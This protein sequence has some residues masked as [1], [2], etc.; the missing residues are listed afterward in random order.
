MNREQQLNDNFRVATLERY[1]ILDT[2]PEK[3]LDDITALAAQICGTP[4]AFISLI[5]KNRQWFKSKFG[6]EISQT[7]RNVAF[8]NHTIQHQ[9]L[10]IVPDA[11]K[12]ERFVNN[13]LVTGPPNICFYAGTPLISPDGAAIGALCVIDHEPRVLT[14][15]QEKGLRILGRQVI[16]HLELRCKAHELLESENKFR[17]LSNNIDDVLW[18][19]STD[20]KEVYYVSLGYEK[21]WGR[22]VMDLYA[23]SQDW[24]NTI[25]PED[26]QMVLD[27]LAKLRKNK[28]N[29]SVE[30]RIRRPNGEIR[31]IHGRGFQVLNSD[32]KLERLT[33]IASDI[34]ENK[35]ADIAKSRL[36]AIVEFSDDAIIG[37]DL[38]SIIT[39]WNRGAEKIFGYTADEMVGT[40]IM[41]LIPTDRIDEEN[42][43]LSKI[44]NGESVEH[45]ETQR[46]TKDGRLIDISVTASPIKN[47]VSG[48][49]IGV[50]KV[51]RDITERKQA[52]MKIAE[53]AALLDKAHDAI[54]V[55]DLEGRIL[56]WNNGA[57]RLY[58]WTGQEILGRNIGE[59]LYH[60]TNQFK[61]LNNRTI[62]QGEWYGEI[63]H[64]TKSGSKRIIDAHWTLI[65]DNQGQPKSVLA[66]NTDITEK[67]KIEAQFMR[68]QRME[69]IGVLAGGI[70]HDLNNILSPIMMSIS[71]LRTLLKNPETDEI[72]EAIEVSAKRGADIVRQVLSFARGMERCTN[73]KD[74][75]GTYW[76]I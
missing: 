48:K 41:R 45:F 43:I 66:I 42:H 1:N 17:M 18:I 74:S 27:S 57:E 47:P 54:I 71:V 6:I 12:D 7:P 70:A 62:F 31:W 39:S 19:T 22:K 20:S 46:L 67:K 61:V 14:P 21:I 2:P 3:T 53:Q 36:G 65:R 25:V 35:H 8:C 75:P 64:Q 29:L 49:P 38:N 55:R 33:G 34:T 13:T 73:R 58:G 11:T 9:D 68:A 63:T 60:D 32:G 23:N 44:K 59:L 51:A 15:L 5:D 24:I 16:T 50:S 37:K 52:E 76:R 26:R 10:F 40:T 4:I 28:Q 30:Y 72:I 69:S 56:Y